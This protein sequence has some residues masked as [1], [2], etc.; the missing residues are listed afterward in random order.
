MNEAAINELIETN[1]ELVKQINQL[2]NED[3][4][5]RIEN[6]EI[7]INEISYNTKMT[8]D[9]FIVPKEPKPNKKLSKTDEELINELKA[10][11]LK[12]KR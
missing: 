11:W 2:M 4:L 6:L 5:K 10:K 1:K 8:K 12:Q 7:I 9:F 3:I